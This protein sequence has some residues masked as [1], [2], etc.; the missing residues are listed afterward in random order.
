MERVTGNRSGPTDI[1]FL[2]GHSDITGDP[3]KVLMQITEEE[4]WRALMIKTLVLLDQRID[5]EIS[6][7]EYVQ[8]ALASLGEEE[9]LGQVVDKICMIKC[10]R[11]E[12]KIKGTPEEGAEFF[13][14]FSL[15]C[16]GVFL[17]VDLIPPRLNC[18]GIFDFAAF[19]PKEQIQ[20]DEQIRT[21]FGAHY[22]LMNSLYPNFHAI[23]EGCE[24]VCECEGAGFECFDS[25]FTETAID[26]L[27]KA[28]PMSLKKAMML[29]SPTVVSFFW[30]LWKRRFPWQASKWQLGAKLY[31]EELRINEF[32]YGAPSEEARRR[33]MIE[34][35]QRS[36][37]IRKKNE[38][39]FKFW[40]IT[41]HWG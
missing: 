39:D 11:K 12:Y 5:S 22:Y 18:V 21:F 30:A 9:S 4:L 28:Y 34:N 1:P 40:K 16:P 6:D 33:L 32:F 29:N 20:T 7:F 37:Q 8:F 41:Q 17:A 3:A 25:S 36:L 2:R 14:R 24:V 35:V 26:T 19:R 38:D 27:F 23:R 15:M 31:P 10:F 13:D